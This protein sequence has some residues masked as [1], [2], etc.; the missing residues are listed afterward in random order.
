MLMEGIYHGGNSG[1]WIVI[2]VIH[3]YNQITS[4]KRG[5]LIEFLAHHLFGVGANIPNMESSFFMLVYEV[6]NQFLCEFLFVCV[7]VI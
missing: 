2:I 6:V 5:D 1:G 7:A 3:D 4:A